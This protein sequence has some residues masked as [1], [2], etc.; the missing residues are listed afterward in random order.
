MKTFKRN[1]N[2]IDTS[3]TEYNKIVKYYNQMEWKGLVENKNQF[4]VDQLSQSDAKNVYV[5]DHGS[6]VSRDPL[7]EEALSDDILLEGYILKDIVTYGKVSIY[8]TYSTNDNT[9]RITT[10][11][12]SGNTLDNITKYNI[13]NINNYIICFNDKGAK[14]FD[15]NEQ[16]KGWQDFNDF[17]EIP[18]I[19]RV[20]GA[21]STEYK[22]NNF[23]KKYKKEYIWTK[24]VQTQLPDGNAD[25][26]LI[27]NGVLLDNYELNNANV[28]TDYN[29]VKLL[30]YNVTSPRQQDS[31][32]YKIKDGIATIAYNTALDTVIIAIG[33]NDH[34]EL[35]ID[36]GTSYK[37]ISYPS[38]TD[39]NSTNSTGFL[40]CTLSEDGEYFCFV[41]K[42]GIYYCNLG[43]YTWGRISA[44]V[45]DETEIVGDTISQICFKTKDIF[46]FI[47][48]SRY[49]EE[50]E[51]RLYF[52]GPSLYMGNDPT[53][54]SQLGYITKFDTLQ[55]NETT[56]T[57]EY[58][59]VDIIDLLKYPEVSVTGF[60]NRVTKL[61]TP[62]LKMYNIK[63]YQEDPV[64]IIAMSGYQGENSVYGDNQSVLVTVFGG[65]N[66]WNKRHSSV[67]SNGTMFSMVINPK[68]N[69]G[70]P[71]Q[72]AIYQAETLFILDCNQIFEKT[73]N[74]S[75]DYTLINSLQFTLLYSSKPINTIN[76]GWYKGTLTVEMSTME[77]PTKDN[78]SINGLFSQSGFG[79]MPPDTNLYGIVPPIL[80]NQG[81]LYIVPI[82]SQSA[83]YHIRT[84]FYLHLTT[85]LYTT[86]IDTIYNQIA[87]I[88]QA[89]G[90]EDKYYIFGDKESDGLGI[91][92]T[93]D[94]T[95]SDQI[96][97]TYL[98]D[99][100][101]VYSEVPDISYSD[102]ELYLGF[103][104]ILSITNNT[105]DDNDKILLN[106]PSINDQKFINDISNMINISTTDIALFFEDNV[107]ICSKVE[108]ET[109]GF[110]Y[111]YYP[112]KLSTGTRK[113]DSIINTIEG[114]YTIFPTK[115]GLA[116]MNY[117]AFMA[118]T[119]QVLTYI[120]DNIEDRYDKFYA[121]SDTIKLLQVRDK[122]YLTN[123]TGDIL[124][125]NLD[126][127]QWWY[128][129]VPIKISK[130]I[131][132][133]IDFKLIANK[134][135]KFGEHKI[136]K[137]FPFTPNEKYI[138]WF[139]ISQPLH[140]K[141]PN[142]YK[143]LKQLVFQL[144][145]DI[146]KTERH[147]IDVQIQCYRKRLSTKDPEVIAFTIEELRTFVK[148][149][150]YWK[151]N[152]IQYALASDNEN[153]IPTKLRLNGISVK[154][155][156]G[157]EVR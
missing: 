133:Q 54:D 99:N 21:E 75:D 122:L 72:N 130:M 59:E 88:N 119:D 129:E 24:E 25:V 103:G 138:D 85:S 23:T 45:G 142:Y 110:R 108:D 28:G 156:L 95:S 124:I 83:G 1:V 116:L 82:Y 140:M 14:V 106:L 121:N 74:T 67:E 118:T 151:I 131:T 154:Y 2:E 3:L 114:S 26:E 150:N 149:F 51:A 144:L 91:L 15:I 146:D 64:W 128:W 68:G 60:E 102:T 44:N 42:T 134:L 34:F 48:Y 155:E 46:S 101:S 57:Y 90:L 135:Y 69:P 111:D 12:Q 53:K 127:G 37:S 145:D 113:G 36:G 97:F 13:A 65:P 7:I 104:N 92:M 18:V 66:M 6:L 105:V 139:I 31:Q 50:E 29:I 5:D 17:V 16:N 4:S 96:I 10:D 61:Y 33:H 77:S 62:S 132:N 9:Y 100:N 47:I 148:R 11:G 157:E 98:Y 78:I 19:E 123:G 22:K 89:Y 137:D 30:D 39:T 8:V 43:D 84:D 152:E 136:Y 32:M 71:G 35:S 63:G 143:N 58:Y 80:L 126:Q 55:E 27:S 81:I 70:L 107:I 147:T 153:I 40:G 94:L 38:Y 109:L 56:K 115:R 41:A 141:A 120:T 52:H 112:T 87:N 93:N 20:V 86:R 73:L 49:E 76:R 79:P 125:Y 117:Q